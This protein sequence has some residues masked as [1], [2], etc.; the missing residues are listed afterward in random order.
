MKIFYITAAL[1]FGGGEQFFVPE[2]RE[3]KR[4][5]NE[6]VIIPRDGHGKCSHPSA[7]EL[8]SITVGTRIISA[9]IVLDAVREAARSPRRVLRAARV[10]LQD[11][12]LRTLAKNLIVFP[13]AL[14]LARRARE[15]K[16]EHIHA[17]WASTTATMALVA[18]EVSGISWSFTAHRGDISENNLLAAKAQ[19][20]EFVRFIAEDGLSTAEQLVGAAALNKAVVLHLGIDVPE[21]LGEHPR[22][23]GWP[24][25]FCAASLIPRKGQRFLIE[26]IAQLRD[27]RLDVRVEF[28]GDGE[29]RAACEEQARLWYRCR[30]RSVHCIQEGGR[31]VSINTMA[32]RYPSYRLMD[33]CLFGGYKDCNNRTNIFNRSC[34]TIIASVI[35]PQ[36]NP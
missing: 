25:L 9:K 29:S 23:S 22:M 4:T 7:R 33:S 31:R 3:L 16:A 26:A 14:W 20:A 2:V 32:A 28:A 11:R 34:V 21:V 6:V 35:I 36:K 30:L 10:L 5:G 12:Q 15:A 17:H 1:P 8:L 18:S 19:R 13:K 27:E 24:T